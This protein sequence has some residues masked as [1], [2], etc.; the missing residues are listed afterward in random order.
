MTSVW[1]ETEIPVDDDHTT[2]R[3]IEEPSVVVDTGITPAPEVGDRPRIDIGTQIG[4]YVVLDTLGSG[5]MGEVFAVYDRH[6]A[7]KAAIK[8][9]GPPNAREPTQDEGHRLVREAQTMAKLSHPNVVTV[10]EIGLIG[11]R[12]FVAMEFVPGTTLRRWMA[13]P[14]SW[15]E[16]I[17]VFCEAGE[18]LVAAHEQGVIHRDFKPDNV[19]LSDKGRVQVTDF[20]LADMVGAPV[21]SNMDGDDVVTFAN[22]IGQV[23]GTPAYMAPE[24]MRG[25]KA[26]PRGDQFSYCVSLYEALYHKA[27]FRAGTIA[28]RHQQILNGDIQPPP[29]DSRVPRRIFK[30]ISVGMSGD[31]GQRHASMSLLIRELRRAA[32][33]GHRRAIGGAIAA[34]SLVAVVFGLLVS[35]AAS[36][37]ADVCGGAQEQWSGIW[38]QGVRDARRLAFSSLESGEQVWAQV[39]RQLDAHTARWNGA[40]A[41]N[42]RATRIQHSQAQPIYELRN[43]CLA[44]AR[45]EVEALVALFA[46]PGPEIIRNAQPAVHNLADPDH[47]SPLSVSFMVGEPRTA[48]GDGQGRARVEK[49]IATARGRYNLG[50]FTQSLAIAQEAA[51]AS[52][53]AGLDD[54]A[55]EAHYAIGRAQWRSGQFAN[56]EESLVRACAGATS[57]GQSWLRAECLT[58]LVYVI[59]VERKDFKQAS[60]WF[61]MASQS[62]KALGEPKLLRGELLQIYATVLGSHGVAIS[63]RCCRTAAPGWATRTTCTATT[64]TTAASSRRRW[65]SIARATRSARPRFRRITPTSLSR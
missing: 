5:G 18:G 45:S 48:T 1:G 13:Q 38:D 39:E 7:R 44:R 25:E 27:P 24:Q 12:P 22:P 17:R 11:A 56:A 21:D 9:V 35:R 52:A 58:D 29:K 43:T 28:Q 6:L 65:R 61:E 55:V 54:L 53:A 36:D 63:R 47:C 3:S 30:I 8:V 32:T 34:G 42:C 33:A 62:I 59:G 37:P 50:Q 19:L 51:S 40:Y 15:Q 49:L 41:D 23:F 16:T 14:H 4:R 31:P 10:F 64:S 20:G 57:M 26:D 2:A 46:K 60:L